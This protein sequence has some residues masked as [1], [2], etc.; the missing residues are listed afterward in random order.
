MTVIATAGSKEKAG[1]CEQSV[2]LRIQI[3]VHASVFLPSLNQNKSRMV[4]RMGLDLQP[5]SLPPPI[6]RPRLMS[7]HLL[8][9]G[10]ALH[11]NTYNLTS[12]STQSLSQPSPNSPSLP[13]ILHDSH[14][15]FFCMTCK[16][17][18]VTLDEGRTSTCFFPRSSAL[19]MVLR[20]SANTLMRTMAVTE[21]L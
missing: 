18:T 13:S 19:E 6:R 5:L 11:M 3:K 12:L 9:H 1:L 20:A 17:L 4:L 16:N 15:P 21:D 14:A 8:R 10:Y 2:S 7:L